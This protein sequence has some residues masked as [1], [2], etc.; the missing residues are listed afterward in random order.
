MCLKAHPVLLGYSKMVS[1]FNSANDRA[2]IISGHVA[3]YNELVDCLERS[4]RPSWLPDSLKHAKMNVKELL[5]MDPSDEQWTKM[6]ESLWNSNWN[7]DKKPPAFIVDQQVRCGIA[8]V[9]SLACIEEEK[10]RLARE[11]LNA[12]T[13][14]VQSVDSLIRIMDDIHRMSYKFH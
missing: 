5:N 12:C 8:A 3:Q 9:L 14:I 6:W 2:R 10:L 7:L 13:W 1:V 11:E 4:V